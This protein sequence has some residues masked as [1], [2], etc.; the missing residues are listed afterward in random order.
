MMKK[1]I[2]II[3]GGPSS[4]HEVSA[5]SGAGVLSGIDK[6]LFDPLLIGITKSGQWVLLPNDYPLEISNGA[7]PT[8]ELTSNQIELTENGFKLNGA[9]LQIDCVFPVLHGEFGED[10]QIQ[11]LLEN[12]KIAYVGSGVEASAHAMDKSIAKAIFAKSGL[13]IAEGVEVTALNWQKLTMDLIY[14]V[15]VKP[16]S[17]GS[18]RGTHKVKGLDS[19]EA[20][21]SDALTYDDKVLVE[22]AID[23]R[24]IECAVIE[25][26]GVIE[27]SVAGEI[28]V[29]PAFEFYDFQAKYLDSATT[30]QIPANIS[31]S[32]SLKIADQAKTA[33]SALG[34]RGL[35][36][37]DFFYTKKGEIVINELNTMPGFTGT[38]VYP[39]L[40]AASGLTY[41]QLITTLINSA[42]K[43][44]KN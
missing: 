42:L 44:Y 33:F 32:D 43:A 18:S 29:N 26:E 30:V 38:S 20:A 31:Q 41:S 21:I 27:A 37:C 8:I 24:E 15:F 1:K 12:S 23:G 25:R 34:C 4:E 5:L 17:G 40:W 19:L 35:A 6:E 9:P 36:R 28:I 11:Q 3:C 16:A 14:P 13:L 2:A 39:K 22:Q 10:G 7:M